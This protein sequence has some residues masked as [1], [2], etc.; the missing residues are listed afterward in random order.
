MAKDVTYAIEEGRRRQ[1]N[2][3]TATAALSTFKQAVASGLG[4]KDF[5]AVV[6]AIGHPPAKSA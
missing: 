1:V 6:Q 2:M 4:E 3:Q 5:A